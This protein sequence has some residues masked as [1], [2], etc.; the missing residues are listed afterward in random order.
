MPILFTFALFS[1]FHAGTG[2]IDQ[3][4]GLLITL[5]FQ[6]RTAKITYSKWMPETA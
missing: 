1:T 2:G 5:I 6:S 3:V 4:L